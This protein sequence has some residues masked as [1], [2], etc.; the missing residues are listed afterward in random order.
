VSIVLDWGSGERWS[1]ELFYSTYSI[2][3]GRIM[4]NKHFRC[5]FVCF[6]FSASRDARFSD[7]ER[8][9]S[10]E[11]A[12]TQLRNLVVKDAIVAIEYGHYVAQ[13][14]LGEGGTRCVEV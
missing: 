7:S 3:R 9:D 4:L 13:G 14:I 11:W 6:L 1:R 5:A 10:K 2:G 12:E 8:T